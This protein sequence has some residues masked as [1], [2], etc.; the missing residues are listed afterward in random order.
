MG[1][2][3]ATY[4]DMG[5]MKEARELQEE[6]LKLRKKIS[7]IEHPSTILA[8]GNLAVTYSNIGQMKEARE[9]EE[10]VLRLLKEVSLI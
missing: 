4:S 3:A 5:E 9:L 6:V 8:M 7:G 10:E 2:L 1:N